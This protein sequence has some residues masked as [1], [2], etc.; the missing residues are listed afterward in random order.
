M[1]HTDMVLLRKKLRYGLEPTQEVPLC[2]TG[3]HRPTSSPA[4]NLEVCMGMGI[5]IPMG[6][7]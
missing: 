5:P 1:R 2:H 4:Y 6:F 7:P 3:P